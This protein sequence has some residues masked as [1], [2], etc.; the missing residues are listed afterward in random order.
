MI[1]IAS[2]AS[3]E[4]WAQARRLIEEYT[5]WLGV[6]L[7]FQGIERELANLPGDYGPPGGAFFLART[8]DGVP[9]CVGLR[10]LDADT[11]EVK[12][13]YVRPE[14]RGRGVGRRLARA[15]VD[16]G[17][18]LGYARLRLDTLGWMHEAIAL[19]RSLGFRPIPAYYDNPLPDVVYMECVPGPQATA[20]SGPSA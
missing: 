20:A 11:G 17:R 2:P 12:R 13:L 5:A 7:C 19:Y 8:T 1:G 16:A 6:D 15:A 14:A 10:R 4:D 3:A 18:A 9:G